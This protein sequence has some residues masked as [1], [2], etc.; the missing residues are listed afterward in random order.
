MKEVFGQGWIVSQPILLSAELIAMLIE[1]KEIDCSLLIP[2]T[3]NIEQYWGPKSD[4]SVNH[5]K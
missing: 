3:S 5:P 1:L 4:Y 2:C